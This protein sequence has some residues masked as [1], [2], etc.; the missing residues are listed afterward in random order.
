MVGTT[1]SHYRIIEKIDAG[2]MGVVYKARDTRLG[3][4]VALKFLG[5]ER[6]QDN[7][8][9]Q[10]FLREARAAAA[11]DHVNICALFDADTTDDG[12]PY[13][14]MAYYE[15]STLARKIADG[16]HPARALEIATQVARGLNVAHVAGVVHRDIKP[17]N[18]LITKSGGV[19]IVD[20]GVASLAGAIDL[21]QPDTPIGT[22]AYMSPEQMRSD[23]VDH[24]TDLWSLGVVLYE[25]LTSQR[26]FGGDSV[27]AL[28][29]KVLHA[30]PKPWKTE[31]PKVRAIVE[32]ALQKDPEK[33]Y[34]SALDLLCD[35]E[36][37]A[38][39][40]GTKPVPVPVPPKPIPWWAWV[41]VAMVLLAAVGILLTPSWRAQARGVVADLLPAW[42]VTEPSESGAVDGNRVAYELYLESMGL[43][44]RWD[45]SENVGTA[46]TR[47]KKALDIDSGFA[48]AEALLG[49]AYRLRYVLEQ[50]TADLAL[51]LEHALAA[52]SM[53]P[54]LA[55]VQITLGR[56][57]ST[58]GENDLAQEALSKSLRLD[59]YNADG[60]LAMARLKEKLGRPEEAEEEHLLAVKL[61]PERWKTYDELGHFYYG[62][63][64]YEEAIE[65]WRK[66][67]SLTP[68]NA[69]AHV[70]LG[71]ALAATGDA[72]EA[73]EMYE[74]A[75]EAEPH[76][77]AFMNLGNY[78]LRECRFA[79]SATMFDKALQLNDRDYLTWGNAGY[80]FS[81]AGDKKEETRA[82]FERAVS[83]A[84]EAAARS[85]RSLNVHLCLASFYAKLGRREEALKRLDTALVLAPDHRDVSVVAA[86][87]YELIADRDAA[88]EA[89]NRA[90]EKD[91]PL[92]EFRCNPD[93]ADLLDDPRVAAKP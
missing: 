3:R 65:Q 35:L 92:E 74:Q 72:D 82:A 78:Y 75:V 2:N 54:E 5:R 46:I 40:D 17:S 34:P 81:W 58:R 36:R 22:P 23:K 26:P 28:M 76:Y 68:D 42:S 84:E 53:D 63:S 57:H 67:L 61:Q 15:A 50:D 93:L 62:Q 39:G 44:D 49:E 51:A 27:P 29:H 10:R 38:P 45:K 64:R 55:Q 16:I 4:T 25:M 77:K 43:L 33:R 13:I 9:R 8:A 52:A 73:R 37:A 12:S 91:F 21:T 90:I 85:P 66:V 79:E 83:M 30:P 1:I 59:A 19:K 20:F 32:R 69:L 48:L 88:V 14:V 70:N 87:V 18:I 86:E 60:H 89:L 24:R 47:L 41:A 11:L 71:A 31:A 80:A 7:A 6:T 56:V